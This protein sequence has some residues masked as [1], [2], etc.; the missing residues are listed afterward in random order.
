MKGGMGMSGLTSVWNSP[1]MRPERT[2]AD[3]HDARGRHLRP[4]RLDVEDDEVGFT[5]RAALVVLAEHLD[6]EAAV[7]DAQAP[8][9]ADQFVDERGGGGLVQ[10]GQF[11]DVGAD[12]CGGRAP[13][14]GVQKPEGL[15][16]ERRVR[17]EVAEG[18]HR[19]E[20]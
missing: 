8:V 16:D 20:V 1:T 11:E 3:L 18:L 15:F 5:E 9:L 7:G 12:L 6:L 17:H 2:C 14:A 13:A 4:R 19:P 10:V